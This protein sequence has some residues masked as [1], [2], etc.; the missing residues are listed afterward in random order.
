M[1]SRIAAVLCVIA[2]VLV[3]ARGGKLSG[4]SWGASWSPP[5]VQPA[6][7]PVYLVCSPDPVPALPVTY[8]TPPDGAV[9]VEWESTGRI[10]AMTFWNAPD[11]APRVR[12][13]TV[14]SVL[15][16]GD[17]EVLDV[18]PLDPGP[19]AVG[20]ITE[21][22]TTPETTTIR[23]QV[24]GCPSQKCKIYSIVPATGPTQRFCGCNQNPTPNPVTPSPAPPTPSPSPNPS[25]S[26]S[27]NRT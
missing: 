3:Y 24:N 10:V 5:A 12:T 16:N 19:Q 22:V 26:P 23:C 7:M 21:I 14:A 18:V 25:P 8:E 15:F 17:G 20:C 1:R 9:S 2:L 6:A 4:D 13:G 27:P 11:I